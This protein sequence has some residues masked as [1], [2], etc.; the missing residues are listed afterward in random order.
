MAYLDSMLHC[1]TLPEL[2]GSELRAVSGTSLQISGF[3]GQA[4]GR[5]LAGLVVSRRQL[6][7]QARVPDAD[8]S[9]LLDAPISPGHTFGPAVE[10]ILQ[11]S[12]RQLERP[13]HA[14][15]RG[16]GRRWCPAVTMVTRTILIPMAS[17][18]DLKHRLQASV[19]R[20]RQQ[21]RGNEGRGAPVHQRPWR[22]FQRN[23]PR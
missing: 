11:R 18:G 3:Q 8:K 2:L 16:R 7:P 5:G 4:L 13:S 15:S 17:R 6:W 20:S 23:R 22:Q 9:A 1:V 10:E 14:P 19:A 12:H 21:G